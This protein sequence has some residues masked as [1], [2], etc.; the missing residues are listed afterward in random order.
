MPDIQNWGYSRASFQLNNGKI[1][2]GSNTSSN[3][4]AIVDLNNNSVI[5]VEMP[6]VAAWG[7]GFAFS[8]IF[9]E[10]IFV[11]GSVFVETDKGV[12]LD[13]RYMP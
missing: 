11:G 2:V 13:L 8:S 7:N 9:N 12:I 6:L 10:K 4:R 3:I 1:F 5:P